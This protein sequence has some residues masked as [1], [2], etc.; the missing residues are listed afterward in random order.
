[1]NYETVNDPASSSKSGGVPRSEKREAA[2][3]FSRLALKYAV[4]INGGAAVA[5]LAF[6][7]AIGSAGLKPFAVI[8]LTFA[9]AS[10]A[11][12]VF[13]AAWAAWM[14][15]LN[16]NYRHMVG[17]VREQQH[18]FSQGVAR[19]FR[20]LGNRNYWRWRNCLVAS[21]VQFIV[22]VTASCGSFLLQFLMN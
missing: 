21:F 14:G 16:L 2:R 5:L 18:R 10:F 15:Y 6:V 22:G 7:G 1:M 3:D 4:L 12:G 17:L 8:A 13:T 20:G 9:I 19:N 11:L